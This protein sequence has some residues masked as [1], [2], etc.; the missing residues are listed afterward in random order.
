MLKNLAQTLKYT[1]YTALF[2]FL[3]STA[4]TIGNL[5]H[6]FEENA[7]CGV[8]FGAAVW[9]DD[10]PTHA[11][12]D[13]IMAGIELYNDKHV[14]CLILSGGDS[15]YGAHEVDVM[16]RIAIE[17]DVP[18]KDL[19]LDYDGKNT[20]A[21]VRNL[22]ETVESFVMISNDFH[23]GR[24]RL[25]AHKNNIENPYFHAAEYQHGR[26]VKYPYLF[27]REIAG[28]VWYGFVE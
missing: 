27:L 24:I 2:V 6:V 3:S 19:K 16:Q 20:L 12:S 21:T 22:P 11:L 25:L 26:Y 10:Q 14:R 9:R 23:L 13:R 8:V 5:D 17:H 4:W 18:A 15:T 7:E 28:N 1:F